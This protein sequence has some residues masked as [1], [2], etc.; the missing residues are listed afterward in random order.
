MATRESAIIATELL[1]TGR[2]VDILLGVGEIFLLWGAVH[3]WTVFWNEASQPHGGEN[4][5]IQQC[6]IDEIPKTGKKETARDYIESDGFSQDG[7]TYRPLY[8]TCNV[9][10]R[11]GSRI[12]GWSMTGPGN[13]SCEFPNDPYLGDRVNVTDNQYCRED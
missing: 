7:W 6:T 1:T 4:G 10:K 9:G 13:Q 11:P 8:V 5:P 12:T 3:S 2:L